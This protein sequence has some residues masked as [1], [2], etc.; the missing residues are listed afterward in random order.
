MCSFTISFPE[1]LVILVIKMQNIIVQH[2]KTLVQIF[3]ENQ[4]SF[5]SV[6]AALASVALGIVVDC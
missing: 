4:D 5:I 6:G 3:K 2:I 1:I